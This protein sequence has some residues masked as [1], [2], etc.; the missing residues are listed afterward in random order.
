MIFV[1]SYL[2]NQH[3]LES[4]LSSFREKVA[5]TVIT[6]TLSLLSNFNNIYNEFRDRINRKHN[7]LIFNVPDCAHEVSSDSEVTVRELLIDLSLSCIK[8][9]HVRRLGNFGQK[10]RPLLL[11]FEPFSDVIN[12]F[13]SKSQL[14]HIDRCASNIDQRR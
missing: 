4:G 3:V 12:V 8:V 10:T 5:T 1:Q 13:K 6:Q 14:R 2:S 11:K 9:V 7:V